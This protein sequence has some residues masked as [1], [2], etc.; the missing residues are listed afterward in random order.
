MLNSHENVAL[1]EFV[2]GQLVHNALNVFNMIDEQ[3][4]Q[5]NVMLIYLFLIYLNLAKTLVGVCFK[6]YTETAILF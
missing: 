2:L 1:A 6:P 5:V 3:E 4:K